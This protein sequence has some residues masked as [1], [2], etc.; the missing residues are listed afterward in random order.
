LIY[1]IKRPLKFAAKVRTFCQDNMNAFAF[2][3]LYLHISVTKELEKAKL[4][5]TVIKY[6]EIIKKL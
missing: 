1:P 5:E 3:S 2:I 4:S 6:E